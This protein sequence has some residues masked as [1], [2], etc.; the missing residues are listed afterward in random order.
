MKA[1]WKVLLTD[2]CHSGKITPETSNEAVDSQFRQLP[3]GFLTFSATRERERSFED[4]NLST[5]FGIFTYFVVQGLLGQADSSPCDGVVTA[6]ELIEYVRSEVRNYTRARN[7]SQTPTEHSDFDNN[8]ILG[9]NPAC[10]NT[11]STL[12]VPLG[13]IVIE[14]NMDEVEVYLDDKLVGIV[15]KSK[16]L[17]LPGL[18]TGGHTVK[19]VRKGYEPDT[20]Q[21]V[22]VPGQQRSVTLRIQYRREYKQSAIDHVDSGEKL[23]FQGTSNY[24]WLQTNPS[25][26]TRDDVLKARNLFAQALQED[27]TYPKAAY[28][29]AQA[30]QMLGDSRSMIDA[31]QRAVQIDPSYVEALVNYAAALIEEGDPDE[32]IRQLT[33]ALRIEPTNDV[34]YSHMARAYLD[35]RIWD[36]AIQSANQAIALKPANDQ[37]YLWKADALRRQAADEGDRSRRLSAY[38]QAVDVYGTYLQLTN[39]STPGSEKFNYY[40]WGLSAGNRRHADRRGPYASQRSI[41]FMGLCECEAKLGNLQR[42]GDYCQRAIKYDPDEPLAFFLLG[43]VDRDLFNRTNS[44]EYLRLA[45]ASYARMIQINPDLDLSHHA[46]DYIDQIDH[47]LAVMK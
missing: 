44:R 4:P 17:L 14:A 40:F 45:R 6:D 10:A 30:C 37:A 1:R 23:L 41:A 43:N 7:V 42:A 39:F 19:G 25:H 29:L 9:V 35:K 22:V 24:N 33:E 46:R 2:A 5:G 20:K 32:A 11:A 16:P 28:D 8:M 13:S 18:A 3:E 26:Q 36:D 47:L 21:V 34:A 27:P 38:V 12:S 31:F 15:A